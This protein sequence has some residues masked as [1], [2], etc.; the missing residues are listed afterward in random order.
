MLCH[1]CNCVEY[2]RKDLFCITMI[3]TIVFKVFSFFKC[4][5]YLK[6]YCRHHW[7]ILVFMVEYHLN[8]K[9]PE[10]NVLQTLDRLLLSIRLSGSVT[11]PAL[12]LTSSAVNWTHDNGDILKHHLVPNHAV[13]VIQMWRTCD[14]VRYHA[15][16]KK[17]VSYTMKNNQLFKKTSLFS[18]QKWTTQV[19]LSCGLSLVLV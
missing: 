4:F 1:I 3:R 11:P 19:S 2:S 8:H 13:H 12:W 6:M 18:F 14:P 10:Q 7:W 15:E 9:L 17:S 5:F 16:R